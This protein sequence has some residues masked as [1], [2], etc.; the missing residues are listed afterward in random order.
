MTFLHKNNIYRGD[1][2]SQNILWRGSK[3]DESAQIDFDFEFGFIGDSEDP[4]ARYHRG[5][6][7]CWYGSAL[8]QLC[9]YFSPSLDTEAYFF[10]Y[11]YLDETSLSEDSMFFDTL[12]DQIKQRVEFRKNLDA[13]KFENCHKFIL[14]FGKDVINDVDEGMFSTAGNLERYSEKFNQFILPLPQLTRVKKTEEFHQFDDPKSVLV[15][16]IVFF[17]N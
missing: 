13:G 8:L 2:H 7:G 16:Y 5:F 1:I 4:K 14:N 10:I 17:N 6:A 15:L 9:G 12:A 11:F 3:D